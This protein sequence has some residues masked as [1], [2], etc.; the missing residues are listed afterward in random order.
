MANHCNPK[1][2]VSQT[3]YNRVWEPG[4]DPCG[5]VSDP[6]PAKVSGPFGFCRPK[7]GGATPLLGIPLLGT[8]HAVSHLSSSEEHENLP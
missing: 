2:P 7:S 1:N 8:F 6:T 4:P 5:Q 3:K